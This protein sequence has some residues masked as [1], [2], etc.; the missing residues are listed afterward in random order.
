MFVAM[1]RASTRVN[2]SAG[3]PSAALRAPVAESSK[4]GEIA[5]YPSTTVDL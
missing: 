4:I 2:R 3:N 5:G 1:R